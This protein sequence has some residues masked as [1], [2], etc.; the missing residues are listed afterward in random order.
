VLKQRYQ[1]Q[2]K[3]LDGLPPGR[4]LDVGC[5]NGDWMRLMK[6]RGWTVE[7]LEP[8]AEAANPHGLDIC[9][10]T[11]ESA[12][13]APESFDVVTAWAVFEH[14][15]DPMRAFRHVER[16]LK[17]GG[18]LIIVVSN[19]KSL[20]SRFAYQEDIP[21]HLYVFS[22]QTLAEYARAVGLSL[23]TVTHDTRFF[24]GSGRGVVRVRLFQML[25]GSPL[26]Y[27]QAMKLPLA[28]RL[29]YYPL[30]AAAGVPLAALERILMPD[31]LICRLRLNG[32]ILAMMQKPAA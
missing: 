15:H 19:I 9:H 12:D 26:G 30:I 7:G 25:G 21:R 27:F 11:L 29:R 22:E 31:W 2:A 23:K 18:H 17:R 5:A 28:Q 16:W 20:A 32:I 24:G 14:L 3:Y 13:F 8:S 1:L 6:E 10:G 4:L